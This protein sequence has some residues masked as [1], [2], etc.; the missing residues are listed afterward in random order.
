MR[1]D[2]QVNDESEAGRDAATLAAGV[3]GN[4]DGGHKFER[5]EPVSLEPSHPSLFRC[6]STSRRR[7]PEGR[8]L[9]EIYPELR[10]SLSG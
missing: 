5:A 2:K 10:I 8:A 1:I 6:K 3:V 7:P 4:E 9:F